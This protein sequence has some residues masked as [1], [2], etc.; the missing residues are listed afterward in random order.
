MR[1]IYVADSDRRARAEACPYLLQYW[2]LWNRYTQ[3][4]RGG[5]LPDSYDFWRRQAPM[6]HAM[7]FDEILAND[8]VLLGSP[9]TVAE[10]ILRLS[11]QLDLMGLALIFKLGA[12]P[13]DMV[14]RSMTLFG[15]EVVPRLRPVLDRAAR[16]GAASGTWEKAM[17]DIATGRVVS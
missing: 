8:M 7:S 6:L 12:M 14:E 9:Q 4:T 1:E 2:E 3:F 5:Q 15:A 10:A 13:Y 17:T 16:R 11:A